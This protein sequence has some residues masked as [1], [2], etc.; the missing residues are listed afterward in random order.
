MKVGIDSYS[1]HRFFGEVYENQKKPARGMSYER[2]LKRAAALKVDGVSLETCF[3]ESADESYLKRIREMLD[4]G[5][6]EP[7][8][9]WGHPNGFEGGKNP[10]VSE[11]LKRHLKTCEML[12]ATVMRIVGSSL[13]FRNEPRA[14]QIRRLSRLLKEPAKMAGDRGIR[15]AM[16]NHFDFTADEILEILGNVSSEYLG[17]TYDTGNALRIGDDPVK[18]AK[19]LGPH[20]F[21]THTKDVAPIYG[22]DPRDWFYF[23]CVPVGKGVIDFPALVKTLE[24]A[25]YRGLFAIEI[26]YPHPD[27][28]EEDDIVEKSVRYLKK[29]ARG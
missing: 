17:I 7:V 27:Y 19:K 26:D 4:E 6:L 21:A 5:K 25:G 11:D 8:V 10:A 14:P 23:A 9:A 18:A 1:Y 2:F 12:G 22:G 29:L 3:L 28:A 20:I 24:G 16:E 15:L 13:Y